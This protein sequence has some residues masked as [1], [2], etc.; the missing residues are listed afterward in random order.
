MWLDQRWFQVFKQFDSGC[1]TCGSDRAM[2][3]DGRFCSWQHDPD[4]L[5]DKEAELLLKNSGLF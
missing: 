5:D 4:Y 1:L 2:L 3:R